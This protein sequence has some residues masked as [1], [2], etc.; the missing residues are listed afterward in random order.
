MTSPNPGRPAGDGDRDRDAEITALLLGELRAA[1]AAAR[2]RGATDEQVHR[3]IEQRRAA[4]R[5]SLPGAAPDPGEHSG[6]DA[7]AEAV[8]DDA[9]H[10]GDD[11]LDLRGIA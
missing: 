1:M 6:S 9:E 11:P 10:R 2:S 5:Q 7:V 4:L 3:L 8:A